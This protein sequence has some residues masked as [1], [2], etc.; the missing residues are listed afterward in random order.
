[1]QKKGIVLLLVLLCAVAFADIPLPPEQKQ[2]QEELWNNAKCKDEK[3][4]LTCSGSFRD[5]KN[6]GCKRYQNNPKVYRWLARKGNSFFKEKYCQII[7]LD[8]K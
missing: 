7:G 8:K 6:N 1:M 3:N 4:L 5:E 2:K